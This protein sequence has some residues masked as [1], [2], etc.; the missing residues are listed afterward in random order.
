MRLLSFALPLISLPLQSCWT[1]HEACDTA[2]A[3]S[4]LPEGSMPLDH[5]A[6]DE[7]SAG[8]EAWPVPEDL[9]AEIADDKLTLTY[10]DG[11]GRAVTVVYRIEPNE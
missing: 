3:Y 9:R 5:A 10:T 2:E 8:T 11:D 6:T 7:N 1:L 4:S